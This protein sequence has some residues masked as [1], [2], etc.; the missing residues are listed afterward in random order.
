MQEHEILPYTIDLVE[1]IKRSI[2]PDDKAHTLNES[3]VYILQLCDSIL[4]VYYE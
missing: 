2:I 3:E 1:E 4:K